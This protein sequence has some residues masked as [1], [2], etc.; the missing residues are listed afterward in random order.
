MDKK[1]SRATVGLLLPV[2]AKL[3]SELEGEDNKKILIETIKQIVRGYDHELYILQ[4]QNLVGMVHA[5]K[6]DDTEFLIMHAT[7]AL[8]YSLHDP[9]FLELGL[10]I[11]SATVLS[12]T[13]TTTAH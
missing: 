7:S 13:E 4:L 6:P 8:F 1:V 3:V 12:L 11:L 10:D 5:I 9:D 2:F